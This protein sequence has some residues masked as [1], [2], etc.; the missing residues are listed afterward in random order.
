MLGFSLA[1]GKFIFLMPAIHDADGGAGL[2]VASLRVWIA[3]AVAG[4][5]KFAPEPSKAT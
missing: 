2:A 5:G 3:I 1:L 4:D